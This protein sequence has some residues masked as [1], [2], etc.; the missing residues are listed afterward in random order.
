MKQLLDAIFKLIGLVA[1]YVVEPGPVMA[2]CRIGYRS[3]EQR[4]L[5]E[6]IKRGMAALA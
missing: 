1:A 6:V 2:E 3:F 4:V 5:P